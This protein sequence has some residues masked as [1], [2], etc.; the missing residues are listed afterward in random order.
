MGFKIDLTEGTKNSTTRH[1]YYLEGAPGL[2]GEPRVD[3]VLSLATYLLVRGDADGYLLLRSPRHHPIR[4]R[5]ARRYDW[6]MRASLRAFATDWTKPVWR[7][8]AFLEFTLSS[9]AESSST[10]SW[11]CQMQRS[12]R[13]VSGQVTRRSTRTSSQEIISNVFLRTLRL[14]RH[15]PM[16]FSRAGWSTTRSCVSFSFDCFPFLF[17]VSASVVIRTVANACVFSEAM[18]C[19]GPF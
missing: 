1:R 19:L 5:S 6:T 2:V 7:H 17:N 11:A 15:W 16:S 14:L 8:I 12:R 13:V 10:S 18:R 9:A 4:S 3:P